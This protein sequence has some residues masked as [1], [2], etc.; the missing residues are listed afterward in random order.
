MNSLFKGF[1]FELPFL[2][3]TLCFLNSLFFWG[4]F[5]EK[6]FLAFLTIWLVENLTLL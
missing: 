6:S 3:R 4:W 2:G 1:L 5:D